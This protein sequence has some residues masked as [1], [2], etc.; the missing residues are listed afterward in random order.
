MK[1]TSNY[2][3]ISLK[4]ENGSILIALIDFYQMLLEEQK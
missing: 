1:E 3:R 2:H 4:L